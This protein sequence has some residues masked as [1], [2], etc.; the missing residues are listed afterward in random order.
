MLSDIR[1]GI[2]NSN[3]IEVFNINVFFCYLISS[4][5][6]KRWSFKTTFLL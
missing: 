1:S 6:G 3:F 4:R 2:V 5:E